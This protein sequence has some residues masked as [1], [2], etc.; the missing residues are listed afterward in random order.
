M[1]RIYHTSDLH[2]HRGIVPRLQALRRERPGLLFDC[3]DS[4][5]GSQTVYHKNEPIAAELDAAGYDAQAIGNREFHYLFA[6][7]RA[8]AARM[9][10]PLV[11]SNLVDTKGRQLP[12][13]P[14]LRFDV[15]ADAMQPVQVHVLGLLVVQYPTGSPWE[16]VFGW[17]FLEPIGAVESY[18]RDL[19]ESELLVVL[20][21]L[22]LSHDRELARR[23]PRIDIVLGGHSH[24]T[25]AS[26][27]RVA[28]VPIVH[29]GPYGRF[30]SRSEFAYEP[31]R[32]RYAL[33]DFALVPLLQAA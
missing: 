3:G 19:G 22:G 17:R 7:L 30:V 5:R 9:R 20:S 2:D 6:A 27:E 21:H 12:F 13:A 23:V 10:H 8:R 33:R 25:L 32:G 4:L 14:S 29:P 16:R 31:Q 26:P 15:P 18:A 24:D 1:V 11:C 28:G